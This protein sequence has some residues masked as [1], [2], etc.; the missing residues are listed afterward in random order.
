MGSDMLD[1]KVG[2]IYMPPQDMD[3]VALAKPK[4]LKRERRKAAAGAAVAKKQ[5]TSGG[6]AAAAAAG[7]GDSD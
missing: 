7:D 5:R 6:A 2:H 1:G 3:S 4:G